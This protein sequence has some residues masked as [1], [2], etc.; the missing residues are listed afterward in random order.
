MC[1]CNESIH[2]RLV[3]RKVTVLEQRKGQPLA[4]DEDIINEGVDILTF[5]SNS[6]MSSADDMYTP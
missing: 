5:D 4:E 3:F 1:H 2:K 6:W